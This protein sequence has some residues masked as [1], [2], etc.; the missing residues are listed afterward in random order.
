MRVTVPKAADL[1]ALPAI[2]EAH[3]R[4]AGVRH[5][6]RLPHGTRLPGRRDRAGASGLRQDPHQPRQHRRPR[7]VLRSRA[8]SK[9]RGIP[10]RIGVNSGSLGERSAGEIRISPH[11]R[12]W[13]KAHSATSRPRNNSA[14]RRSSCRSSPA[15]FPRPSRAIGCFAERCDYPTHLGITEAGPPPYGAIKSAAGL[16]ALL[17][18]GIGD[19]IRVSLLTPRKEDE[20]DTAFDILQA[21]GRRCGSRK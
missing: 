15:T 11:P 5:S 21:T 2:R 6:L 13:S 3:Q 12:P 19:T 14:T 20:I 7:A 10:M 16:G 9:Q 1:Q 17:L 18:R 8:E 4:A